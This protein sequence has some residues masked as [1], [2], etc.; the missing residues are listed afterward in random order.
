MAASSSKVAAS[1]P[2]APGGAAG[3]IEG[4][5]RTQQ[6]QLLAAAALG[7]NAVEDVHRGRVAARRLRS[8]LKTFRPIL[9]T[10]RARLY[11]A[12][13]RSFAR[14]L[15]AARE[16]DVRRQLLVG[17]AER[18]GTIPPADRER[19][20]ALLEDACVESRLALAR[21]QQEPGWDAL[22]A[23]LERAAAESLVADRAVDLAGL[24][25]LVVRTGRRPVRLIRAGPETASEFHELRLALK[26]CR[27]A[28]EPFGDVAPRATVR[29][30]RRLR[31]A[32][33]CIGEHRDAVQAQAWVRANAHRLGPRL[34]TRL[35]AGLR[36]RERRLRKRT[37]RCSQKVLDAWQG[38]KEATR[39]VR[40]GSSPSPG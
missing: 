9:D 33:D 18:D 12:D 19:L 3:R 10:G 27:Y 39:P 32:Q 15:G 2:A 14:T 11:R 1:S 31:A 26:H 28:L 36:R 38:W 30:A 6:R 13:L 34:A 17:L 29:L 20:D 23:A 40:K 5:I 8:L 7:P 16:A 22:Q 24:L 21:S 35:T 25:G 37:A 4:A